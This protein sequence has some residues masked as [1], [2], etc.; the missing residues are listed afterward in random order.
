MNRSTVVKQLS[1]GVPTDWFG[2]DLTDL[3]ISVLDC[4]NLAHCAAE[5][6]RQA[7]GSPDGR[8]GREYDSATCWVGKA[9]QFIYSL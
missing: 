6:A 7:A 3:E 2:S 4:I 8:F 9:S 5:R 1:A